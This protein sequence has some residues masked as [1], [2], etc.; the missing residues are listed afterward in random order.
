MKPEA[1]KLLN[2]AHALENEQQTK[3]LYRDWAATYEETMIDGLGYLSPTKGAQLF[4]EFVSDHTSK[5]LDVGVGTG[6]V[7]QSLAK[8]GFSDIDGIDYSSEM[9][10]EAKKKNCYKELFK[11]DL[12]RELP[13]DSETYHGILCIGTFT[14]GHVKANCL[15]ELF[16]LLKPGGKFVA[17]I[18]KDYWRQAGFAEKIAQFEETGIARTL[19][20]REDSNYVESTEAESW[21][22]VWEKL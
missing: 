20:S 1:K 8:A 17:V 16:R 13:F 6:L 4:G 7:G 11:A 12:N 22:M 15:D 14:H 5:I 3:E 18:R 9:L 19:A 10:R 2:R 21:F